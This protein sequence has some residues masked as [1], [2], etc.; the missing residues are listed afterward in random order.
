MVPRHSPTSNSCLI[1]S[2]PRRVLKGAISPSQTRRKQVYGCYHHPPVLLV[3]YILRTLSTLSPKPLPTI[4]DKTQAKA[5]TASVRGHP[6]IQQ[7]LPDTPE[8]LLPVVSTSNIPPCAGELEPDALSGGG[9]LDQSIQ[10]K[11]VMRREV[12]FSAGD[13]VSGLVAVKSGRPRWFPGR[14]EEVN[15]DGTLHVCYD[16]GDKETNKSCFEVRP[17]RRPAERAARSRPAAVRRV[18]RDE[19]DAGAATLGPATL[20]HRSESEGA[21]QNEALDTASTVGQE[22]QAASLLSQC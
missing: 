10:P 20:C 9:G 1:R 2:R 21:V 18:V 6:K 22:G 19:Q 7:A 4:L 17:N 3:L 14:V 16:D 12:L 13:M 11:A 8:S 15:E 5:G